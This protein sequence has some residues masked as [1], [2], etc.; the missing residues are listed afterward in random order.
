MF[1]DT[2]KAFQT[3]QDIKSSGSATTP[4]MIVDVLVAESRNKHFA[5]LS[6]IYQ[7]ALKVHQPRSSLHEYSRTASDCSLESCSLQQILQR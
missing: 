3:L 7:D 6:S 1:L 2:I 4:E 5:N